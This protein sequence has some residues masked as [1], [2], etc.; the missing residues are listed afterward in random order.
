M[1]FNSPRAWKDDNR[2]QG[3]GQFPKFRAFRSG[4]LH[5]LKVYPLADPLRD[6][7]RFADLLRRI[8]LEK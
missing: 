8:R 3:N 1:E 7:P 4:P 2:V 5:R 6:D